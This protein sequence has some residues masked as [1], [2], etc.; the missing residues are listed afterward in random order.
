MG[1]G[2]YIVDGGQ[3]LRVSPAH[4]NQVLQMSEMEMALRD[5]QTHFLALDMAKMENG[6]LDFQKDDG[7]NLRK[8]S[9]RDAEPDGTLQWICSTFDPVD[10]CIYDGYYDGRN[11]KIISFAGVLQNG[12]FPLP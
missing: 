8:W 9:V 10:Q 4:P 2:K 6:V 1:L 3:S 7:F 11:R 5:T 12:V